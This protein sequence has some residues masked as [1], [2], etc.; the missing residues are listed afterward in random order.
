MSFSNKIYLSDKHN[1]TSH[2]STPSTNPYR[3]NQP[4]YERNY[5]QARED[6]EEIVSTHD[7]DRVRPWDISHLNSNCSNNE[8]EREK[9]ELVVNISDHILTDA[10][11]KVLAKGM[12]FCPTPGEPNFGD[13]RKI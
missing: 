11:Y 13:L 10:E 2:P 8:E 9:K 6:L 12:K 1:Y 5:F 4:A 7:Q 3:V